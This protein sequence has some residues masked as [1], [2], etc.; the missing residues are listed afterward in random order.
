MQ[1]GP[2]SLSTGWPASLEH[3]PHYEAPTRVEGLTN[4][5]G[6]ISPPHIVKPS[7]SCYPSWGSI[8]KPDARI[9][10]KRAT[11]RPQQGE[12]PGLGKTS[13]PA[14]SKTN[15]PDL[16]KTSSPASPRIV[17]LIPKMPP[18]KRNPPGW[19][20]SRAENVEHLKALLSSLHQ[21]KHHKGN[22]AG[23]AL[24]ERSCFLEGAAAYPRQLPSSTP[25]L[26]TQSS[27]CIAGATSLRTLLRPSSG[28]GASTAKAAIC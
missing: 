27:A 11:H 10:R 28:V 15:S 22:L 14:F 23:E 24:G 26:S 8:Q 19:R 2:R 9:R 25:H 12:Q 21:A 3:E 4:S 20:T 13:D 5:G 1:V 16:N 18:R 17:C 7:T 6:V